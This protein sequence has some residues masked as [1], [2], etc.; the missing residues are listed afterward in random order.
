MH[1]RPCTRE[2]LTVAGMQGEGG[3]VP[4][5]GQS[6][7]ATEVGASRACVRLRLP[8]APDQ[9]VQLVHAP[10]RPEECYY[11]SRTCV[12][13]TRE[14]AEATDDSDEEVVDVGWEVCA[15]LCCAIHRVCPLVHRFNRPTLT[16][17]VWPAS[18]FVRPD[19]A[20]PLLSC[21]SDWLP[22]RLSCRGW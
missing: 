5:T 21:H 20:L 16:L 9:G 19:T 7:P 13:M 11:H 3:S 1:G 2:Q 22:C 8:R 18:N 6:S 17:H 12:P 14:E 10:F 15:P 4:N